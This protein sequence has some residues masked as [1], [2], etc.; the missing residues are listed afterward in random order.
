[1]KVPTFQ[2]FGLT[3][4]QI[5][6]AESRDK[7]ISDIL[8]HHLTVGIGL[9]FGL[10]IYI[11]YFS[12]V[13]PETFLQI[14][15]QVFL[16]GS[17]G[18]ICV[19]IPAMLFKL[20]EMYYFKKVKGNSAEHKTITLYQEERD[21]YDFWQIRKDY[22]FWKMLDGLS[23]EKEVMNVY[24]YLGYTDKPELDDENFEDERIL[25]VDGKLVYFTFYTKIS[26]FKDSAEIDKLLLKMREKGCESL[27]LFSQ[28]GFIKKLTEAYKDE[29]VKFFDI[30]GI[31]KVV[32][33]VKD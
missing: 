17:I 23:F 10:I 14:V 26:E 1:M 19:G 28:S 7:K 27:Y 16:F 8:T 31:I 20:A 13:Q 15:F 32:R 18:I 3:K 21:K 30:N 4:A 11:I 12:K 24:L 6:K 9:V 33:T 29:S 22:S 5:Q 2:K 25:E